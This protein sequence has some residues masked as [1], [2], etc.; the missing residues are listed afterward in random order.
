VVYFT[1]LFP[2]AV[3]FT[4]IIRGVTLPGSREGICGFAVF[5]I[6]GYMSFKTGLPVSQVATAGPGL[7]FVAYPQVLSIMPADLVWAVLFFLMLLTLGL[8]SQIENEPHY[9]R[10]LKYARMPTTHWGPSRN[11]NRIGRYYSDN[12][13]KSLTLNE[14]IKYLEEATGETNFVFTRLWFKNHRLIK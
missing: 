4:L 14:K 12:Y 6:L 11:K 8:D 2:Y 3:I 13:Q 10:M 9:I 1:S 7:A 5:S